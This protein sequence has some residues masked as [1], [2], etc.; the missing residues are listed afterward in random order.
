M[1]GIIAVGVLVGFFS[2]WFKSK[3]EK[4]KEAQNNIEKSLIKGI[5]DFEIQLKKEISKSLYKMLSE[6]DKSVVDNMNKLIIEAEAFQ[7]LLKAELDFCGNKVDVLNKAMMIRVLQHTKHLDFD[8]DVNK[9]VLKDKTII[10]IDRDFKGN[11]ITLKT[12]HQLESKD[13]LKI[14]ELIQSDFKVL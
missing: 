6:Y 8:F 9:Y 14:S 1:W 13:V 2:S 4:I 11:Q 12:T 7:K 5:N 3:A 10:N